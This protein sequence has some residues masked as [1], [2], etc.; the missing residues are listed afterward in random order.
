MGLWARQ[1]LGQESADVGVGPASGRSR[2]GTGCAISRR[3]FTAAGGPG[4][5]PGE[6]HTLLGWGAA[7]CR[8]QAKRR[9]LRKATE[10]APSELIYGV[11]PYTRTMAWSAHHE[12]RGDFERP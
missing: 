5:S 6:H 7:G 1:F 10:A 12:R 11:T 3:A 2:L 8:L 4:P 9:L